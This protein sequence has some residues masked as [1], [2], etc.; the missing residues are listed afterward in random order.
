MNDTVNLIW[1]L[2]GVYMLYVCRRW[3]VIANEMEG[4]AN[5]LE[6]MMREMDDEV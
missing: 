1:A 4:I 2:V 3:H 5:E 6:D